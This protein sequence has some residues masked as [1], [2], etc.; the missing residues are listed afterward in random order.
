MAYIYE[1]IN[2]VNDK[3]YIGKTEFDINKRFKEHCHDA[4]RERN[5]KRPLYRAMQKY[6][7]E[8]FNIQLIEETDLPEEREIY[9]ISQKDTYRNGYNATMGG[10]GKKYLDHDLIISTYQELENVRQTS[11]ALNVSV[12]YISEILKKN[13]IHIKS[14]QEIMTDKYGKQVNM[15]S[16]DGQLL[17]SFDSINAAARYMVENNLTKCKHTTIKQHITEVCLGKRK[18]AAKFKWQYKIN[19]C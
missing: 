11:L 7:I 4:F 16:L 8:H 10:D 18:T 17:K 9:W 5:E 13:H 12:D 1:I 14:T 6:G 15:Y 19:I 3:R 2:D